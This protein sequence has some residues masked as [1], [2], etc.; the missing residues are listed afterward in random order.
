MTITP[1]NG[2]TI[3]PNDGSVP[4]KN[5]GIDDMFVPNQISENLPKTTLDRAPPDSNS[6][7]ITPPQTKQ[8]F[9]DKNPNFNRNVEKTKTLFRYIASAVVSGASA[10]GR[11]ASAVRR[12][13]GSLLTIPGSESD[14]AFWASKGPMTGV[15]P[16]TNRAIEGLI[17]KK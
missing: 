17:K 11:G 6:P 12:G 4:V 5:M 15:G 2:K 13:I 7:N 16:G 8:S 3:Q 9:W 10:V 14:E 1:D